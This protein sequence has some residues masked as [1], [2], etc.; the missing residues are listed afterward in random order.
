MKLVTL[1]N[2]KDA[3]ETVSI[4]TMPIRMAWKI[5]CL[6]RDIN[7]HLQQFS[8]MQNELIKKYGKQN[9]D[10]NVNGEYSIDPEDPE[11]YAPFSAEINALVEI[12]VPIEFEKIKIDDIPFDMSPSD[13][14]TLE[15]MFE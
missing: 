8:E 1:L 7:P 2:S 4:K 11:Q 15:W 9:T 6:I 5:K 12:E 14:M 10:G 13:L 3:L